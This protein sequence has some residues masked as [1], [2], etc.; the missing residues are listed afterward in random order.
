MCCSEMHHILSTRCITNS[1]AH[2]RSHI[3]TQVS[4]DWP[5]VDQSSLDS[6]GLGSEFRRSPAL[7]HA[8]LIL[9]GLAGALE[10]FLFMAKAEIQEGNVEI[11]DAS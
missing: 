8:S 1:V 10:P 9:L 3:S 5:G 6:T 4:V 2:T 11:C 7:F